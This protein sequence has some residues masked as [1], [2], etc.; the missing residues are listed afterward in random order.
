MKLLH[1]LSQS[2]H[3]M[4][5][6]RTVFQT[7][8]I[9]TTQYILLDPNW[10]CTIVLLLLRISLVMTSWTKIGTHNV[11]QII[12]KVRANLLPKTDGLR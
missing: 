1:V 8:A 12:C 7:T 5:C 4:D 10:Y 3:L 11:A 9:S 2:K 6:L